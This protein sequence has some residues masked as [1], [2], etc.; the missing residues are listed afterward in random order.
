VQR[1]VEY[2][3]LN[4]DLS[5]VLYIGIDEISR[6]KGHTYI[7]NVYDLAT[8]NLIWTGE[9]REGATLARF[10]DEFG[11]EATK[12]LIGICCDMWAPYRDVVKA[13][14]KQATFVFDKF[15]IVRHL[16]QAID[17][18]RKQEINDM[19][20]KESETLKG[21][22]YIFLKNPWNLTPKQKARLSNLEKMNLKI[23]RAYLLKE[24]FRKFW[25]YIYPGNARKFLNQWCWWATHSRLEP[26]RDFAQMLRRHEEDLMNYFKLKIT[27]AAVE[28]HNRKAK[29]ISQRAYG[30]RT[31]KTFR[32][33][34]Y[35]CMGGLPMPE[36]AHRF[37]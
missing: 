31:F 2:G 32:L 7:T 12:K 8:G 37:I 9:G 21:T 36:L 11:R 3:L 25:D 5:N 30:Y 29:V 16:M 13:R 4:R 10:F 17:S 33:A 24:N 35:H 20:K 1:C 23:N 18:I 28:G 27:S 15:H 26:F 6:R 34:L 19:D 14:A 22:K